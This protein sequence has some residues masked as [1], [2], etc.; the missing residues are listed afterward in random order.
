VLSGIE[1]D[2]A[3]ER[4]GGQKLLVVDVVLIEKIL[5]SLNVIKL[6]EGH[7]GFSPGFAFDRFQKL[8]EDQNIH[9]FKISRIH[10]D[11]AFAG[12]VT[13]TKQSKSK[14]SQRKAMDQCEEAAESRGKVCKQ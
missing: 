9:H 3:T 2:S 4:S 7:G 1:R 8:L 6:V 13:L 11:R 14:Q 12:K 10:S 5:T